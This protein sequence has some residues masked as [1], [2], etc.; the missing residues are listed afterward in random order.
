MLWCVTRLDLFAPALTQAGLDP[1][2]V[3]HVEAGDERTVL[4][5]CEEGLR[6]GGLGGVVAEV[7][8]LSMTASRRLQLAAETLRHDRHR[9]APL[10]AG[11]RGGRF[12]PA[13]GLGHPLAG[14]RPAF[15]AVAGARH[16]P[17]PLAGR[18]DPQPGRGMC[19]VRAGGV[20]CRGSSRSSC[21]PGRPIGCGAGWA[22]PHLR[23]RRRWSWSAAIGRRRVVTAANAAARAAR[24][25]SRHAGHPGPGAGPRSADP[26]MPIPSED[27]AALER[28]ALWALK[29]YAPVVAADPP[30]GLMIDASGAAHLHGGESAMLADLVGRLGQAG[31]AARA[32]MAATHGAAHALARY[33]AQPTLVAGNDAT[34]GSLADLP[35]AALRL[36]A[37]LVVALRRLGFDRIG[38]LAAQPRAPLALRFGPELGRRL[39]QAYRSPG[40]ADRPRCCA[41]ICCRSAVPLPNRSVRP[42]RSPATPASWCQTLCMIAGGQ[43]PGCPPPRSAVLSRRQPD[44]GDPRR[45]RQAGARCQAADPAAV[46]PAGDVD[47]GFGI[48]LMTPDGGDRR[49]ARLPPGRDRPGRGARAGRL[50]PRRYPGQSRRAASG[51]TASLRWRATFPSARSARWQ[52]W[53]SPAGERWP[54]ALAAAGA[55]AAHARADRDPGAAAGS[56]A[57]S[58]HLARHP[59]PREARRRA[60][61]GLWRMVAARR[62]A[63]AVRDYFQVEDRGRRALLAVPRRRRRGCRHR[64][65]ALVPA[66]RVRMSALRRAAMHLAFLASCAAPAP[67]RSCSP[68]RPC[69]ASRPWRITDRNSL[70]GIVRAHEAAKATGRAA[71]RRLPARPDRRHLRPR[72]SDRPAR[73]CAPLPAAV[74]RQEARRQGECHARLGRP[75]RLW[76]GP[77]RGARARRGRTRTARSSCAGCETPSATG[78]MW[79]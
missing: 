77:D 68:R 12:R 45:H 56:S 25:P 19:R 35:I 61:A 3:I 4:A 75:R 21:R 62:R 16:R 31:I 71:D 1:D 7:A 49:T 34:V 14:D 76:R 47:P 5:C 60:G 64:L 36:P 8:R 33:R 43:G 67:A 26:S 40:R 74:A 38:E 32:A 6:H 73:L 20:R 57:R 28:L 72:L 58:F 30:D 78:P 44:R 41:P 46:R 11:H 65:A 13:D 23:L 69:S 42:R 15:D 55:P 66:R 59:P 50:R 10:A 9:G 37:E 70:A 17:G 29:L 24:T 54:A 18:A 52:P 2:R 79:R 63:A 48:E 51:C 22:Q 53:P 39:D 27:A